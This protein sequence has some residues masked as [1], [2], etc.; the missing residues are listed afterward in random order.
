MKILYY[1]L[2]I[3]IVVSLGLLAL[4]FYVQRHIDRTVI[5]RVEDIIGGE[6]FKYGPDDYTWERSI[7]EAAVNR[8]RSTPE[9]DRYILLNGK[10]VDMKICDRGGYYEVRIFSNRQKLGPSPVVLIEKETNIVIYSYLEQ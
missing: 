6:C 5:S 3:G 2:I 9:N 1:K 7:Y 10:V 8:M 4:Y